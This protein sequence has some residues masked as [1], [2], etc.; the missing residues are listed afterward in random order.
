MHTSTEL[1]V[2]GVRVISLSLS[3][4]D[5]RRVAG[6]HGAYDQAMRYRLFGELQPRVTSADAM[7]AVMAWNDYQHDTIAHGPTDAIMSRGDLGAFGRAGG[8]IDAKISSVALASDGLSTA[9]RAGP[10]NDNQPTFWYAAQGSNAAAAA[11][12]RTVASTWGRLRARAG[13]CGHAPLALVRQL[14]VCAMADAQWPL[15]A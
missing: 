9:A 11:A 8:G 6:A 7:R 5:T 13:P 14:T 10:T 1:S 15:C 4:A 2:C 12:H 3:F